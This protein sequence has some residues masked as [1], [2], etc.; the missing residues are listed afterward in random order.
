MKGKLYAQAKSQS[1]TLEYK[2]VAEARILATIM[3]IFNERMDHQEEM[4]GQHHIMMYSFKAGINKFG[5]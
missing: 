1:Q 4:F 5:E 3:T 2:S